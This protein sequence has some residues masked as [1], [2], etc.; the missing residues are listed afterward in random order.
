MPTAQPCSMRAIAANVANV[1]ESLATARM[2]VART[3]IDAPHVAIGS[4]LEIEADFIRRGASLGHAAGRARAHVVGLWG[5]EPGA[6]RRPAHMEGLTVGLWGHTGCARGPTHAKGAPPSTDAPSRPSTQP[7]RLDGAHTR[8]CH[9]R[10]THGGGHPLSAVRSARLG[11]VRRA[12]GAVRRAWHTGREG[13]EQAGDHGVHAA[14]A[15]LDRQEG[16]DHRDVELAGES[17]R[18]RERRHHPPLAHQLAL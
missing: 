5:H 15:A 8:A 6:R 3:T 9:T 1:T 14:R 16:H 17:I 10:G 13:E 11:A 2:P 4:T 7:T 18:R 12:R